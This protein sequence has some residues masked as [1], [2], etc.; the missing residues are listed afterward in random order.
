[1]YFLLTKPL[2]NFLFVISI[3]MISYFLFVTDFFFHFL[4][5]FLSSIPALE[6]PSLPLQLGKDLTASLYLYAT[7]L[8][9]S[10]IFFHL[11][12]NCRWCRCRQVLFIFFFWI[13]FISLLYRLNNPLKL[14][15]MWSQKGHLA[16][17]KNYCLNSCPSTWALSISG[18]HIIKLQIVTK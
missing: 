14:Q 11:F 13:K 17:W 7:T 4:L 2:L 6:P 8:L 10:L 3:Q 9:S 5:S 15:C 1:M 12:P 16:S 18:K